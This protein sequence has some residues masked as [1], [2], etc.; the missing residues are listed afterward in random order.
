MFYFL[1]IAFYLS[2]K[3][4]K[5]VISYIHGAIWNIADAE[6]AELSDSDGCQKEEGGCDNI[7]WWSNES[8]EQKHGK[9][10]SMKTQK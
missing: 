9:I 1:C 7:E 10:G 8:L 2:N 6:L 5:K 3:K 4:Y